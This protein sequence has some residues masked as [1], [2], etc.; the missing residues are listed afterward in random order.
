MSTTPMFTA[1][2]MTLRDWFAGQV[3]AARLA[4]PY[5]T[6]AELQNG[7]KLAAWAYGVAKAMMVERERIYAE[8]ERA[9]WDPAV[10]PPAADKPP[11]P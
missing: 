1:E 7:A 11:E 6:Q 10:P 2:G 8:E 9:M 3:L 4:H 5:T